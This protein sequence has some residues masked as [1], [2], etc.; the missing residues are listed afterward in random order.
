LYRYFVSQSSEYCRHNPLCCFSTSVCFCQHIFRY[1]FNPETFGNTLLAPGILNLVTRCEWSAS[2]PSR[3]TS[4][5]TASR[6]H[7]MGGGG[8]GEGTRAG[9]D[10]V[11]KRK[12]HCPCW[13]SNPVTILSELHRLLPET[14]YF[15][16]YMNKVV[17]ATRESLS[18]STER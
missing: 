14:L 17:K 1:R 18:S 4:E 9:L 2:R 16:E 7:R 5:E 10:A 11:A 12:L 3:F 6:T 15:Y 8:G 13:E